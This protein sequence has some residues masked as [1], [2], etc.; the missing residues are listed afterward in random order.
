MRQSLGLIQDAPS[1]CGLW[2][3]HEEREVSEESGGSS[4]R[5][6]G[7]RFPAAKSSTVAPGLLPTRPF[8]KNGFV[9]VCG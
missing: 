2:R 8:P 7:D 9:L 6:S 5:L 3:G 4:V 1:T